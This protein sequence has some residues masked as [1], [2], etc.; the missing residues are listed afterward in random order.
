[1]PKV[2]EAHRAARRRQV[3]D[4]AMECFARQGFHRTTMHDIVRQAGLS[5]GAVYGYFASKDDIIEAIAADR[6]MRERD[7][8]RQ[9]HGLPVAGILR[10][11]AREFLGGLTQPQERNER[12]L[13]VQVWAEALREPRVLRLVRQG[14]DEPLHLLTDVIRQAQSRGEIAPLDPESISRAIMAL[15]H[16]FVLQQSWDPGVAVEPYLAVIDAAIDAMVAH[17]DTAG[18]RP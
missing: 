1:M 9:T 11:L 15:F 16:G 10:R 12:R 2:N 17:P 8:I 4:A 6:H 18:R 3:L 7:L 13:G 5:A 14:I